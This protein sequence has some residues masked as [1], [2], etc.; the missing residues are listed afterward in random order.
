MRLEMLRGAVGGF[1]EKGDGFGVGAVWLGGW[2]GG[3][4]WFHSD[5]G[6]IG[7][8]DAGLVDQRGE[9][10]AGGAGG[11]GNDAAGEHFGV[12]LVPHGGGV[13][14]RRVVGEHEREEVVGGVLLLRCQ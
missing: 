8:F 9:A 3:G 13:P 4:A 7:E 1:L 14:L 6:G 11:I 2:V 10:F 5:L 12:F